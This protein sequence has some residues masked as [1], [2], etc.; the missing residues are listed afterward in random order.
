MTSPTGVSS[1]QNHVMARGSLVNFRFVVYM[2][3]V[4]YKGLLFRALFHFTN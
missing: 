3:D 4:L 1:A 2:H